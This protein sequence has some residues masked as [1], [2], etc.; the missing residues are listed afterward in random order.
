[1][2]RTQRALL[3]IS[4]LSVSA[5]MLGA[6]LAHH[7]CH[8][9]HAQLRP[10]SGFDYYVGLMSISFSDGATGRWQPPQTYYEARI[11]VVDIQCG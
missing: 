6:C 10:L 3:L 4:I 8:F 2:N 5:V 1:M 11:G 7:S 9:L